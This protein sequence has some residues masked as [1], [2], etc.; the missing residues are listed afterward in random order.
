[1]K[2][3]A[4]QLILEAEKRWLDEMIFQVNRAFSDVY[5]PSHDGSHHKR[6]WNY[7]KIL[8]LELSEN[9]PH[10]DKTVVEGLLISS[11]Y[12][13]QGMAFT[14]RKDHGKISR[15]ICRDYFE[16]YNSGIPGNLPGILH[17]IEMHDI[18]DKLFDDVIS[19]DEKPTLQT[20]IRISDDMD[21]FGIM[22]IYRY[23]EIYL[24]RGTDI[25]NLGREVNENAGVRFDNLSRSCR[26][27]PDLVESVR[28]RYLQTI[29]F[30][31]EYNRQISSS[32]DPEN[33]FTG[34]PGV[35]NYIRKLGLE[36]KIYPSE[37]LNHLEDTEDTSFVKKFFN[38]LGHEHSHPG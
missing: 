24:H 26:H 9:N 28:K 21:A 12:H 4:I 30:Y 18:K 35:V 16:S 14:S 33:D 5:L 6:V 7:G 10:L 31:D 2:E 22:G 32:P 13:D 1:L 27:L 20:L 23:A 38:E 19:P 34:H 15:Q 8:L 3:Q 29:S 36:R 11:F 25:M 37:F 17:A